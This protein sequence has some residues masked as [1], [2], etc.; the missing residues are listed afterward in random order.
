M[1]EVLPTMVVVMVILHLHLGRPFAV[2]E[3]GLLLLKNLLLFLKS[4]AQWGKM[5]LFVVLHY[6]VSDSATGIFF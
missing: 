2:H 1:V 6:T 4:L 3:L 5:A